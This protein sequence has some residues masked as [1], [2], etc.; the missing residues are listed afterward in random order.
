MKLRAAWR[1]IAIGSM[2]L[3]KS[4]VLQSPTKAGS[5]AGG[6]GSWGR[7]P[8]VHQTTETLGALASRRAGGAGATA[9]EQLEARAPAE[10]IA[11]TIKIIKTSANSAITSIDETARILSLK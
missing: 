7:W 5:T 1:A 11:G 4:W 6:T 10:A 3:R 8:M 9:E 2:K